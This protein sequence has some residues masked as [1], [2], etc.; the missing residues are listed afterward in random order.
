MPQFF[1]ICRGS[2]PRIHAFSHMRG[3][4]KM[5][6]SIRV[7][8]CA[9]QPFWHAWPITIKWYI[10]ENCLKMKK[11]YIELLPLLFTTLRT[12]ACACA[13]AWKWKWKWRSSISSY[14]HC[15]LPHSEHVHEAAVF[16]MYTDRNL[17]WM[18][19]CTIIVG[20]MTK[21]QKN[22]LVNYHERTPQD[23]YHHLITVPITILL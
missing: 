21:V 13:C 22:K 6:N 17:T 23:N 16:E 18:T 8:M 15:Y 7:F 12:C 19:Y 10:W 5:L 4:P 11:F 1:K 20:S 9:Q 2:H 3:V 14:S